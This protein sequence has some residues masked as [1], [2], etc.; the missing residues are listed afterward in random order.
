MHNLLMQIQLRVGI[1]TYILMVN[2]NW[3][4]GKGMVYRL[5]Q[6]QK[7]EDDTYKYEPMGF[8]L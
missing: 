5:K 6:K 7:G 8:E 3:I 2:G 1:N 4:Q